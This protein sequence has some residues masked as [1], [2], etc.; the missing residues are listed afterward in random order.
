MDAFIVFQGKTCIALGENFPPNTMDNAYFRNSLNMVS[1]LPDYA[2]QLMQRI[3][4]HS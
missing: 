3:R 1:V 4:H 2:Y